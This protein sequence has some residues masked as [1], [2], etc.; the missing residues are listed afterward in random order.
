MYEGVHVHVYVYED[1]I[2]MQLR[3]VGGVDWCTERR[4]EKR[5]GAARMLVA[6][7]MCVCVAW[8][9]W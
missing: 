1:V 2:G 6:V 8:L 9:L 3:A 5:G 4:K 7:Y